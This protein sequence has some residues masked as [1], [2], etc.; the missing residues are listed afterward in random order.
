MNREQF[1]DYI[2]ENYADASGAEIEA[3]RGR[4][5]AQS[6]MADEALKELEI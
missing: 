1:D 4:L 2:A 3:I 5:E 6:D